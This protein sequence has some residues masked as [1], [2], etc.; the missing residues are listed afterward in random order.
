M[1][2]FESIPWRKA[3]AL[4]CSHL[5]RVGAGRR[6][7]MTLVMVLCSDHRKHQD[8]EQPIGRHWEVGTRGWP[9]GQGRARLTKIPRSSRDGAVRQFIDNL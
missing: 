6:V 1:V 8:Q 9:R 3:R 7:K 2:H 5:F 4:S